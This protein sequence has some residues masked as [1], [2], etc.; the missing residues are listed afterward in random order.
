MI[1]TVTPPRVLRIYQVTHATGLSRASAYRLM[2]LGLF[3]K[4]IKIGITAV[5]WLAEDI[6]NFLM[7]R[8]LAAMTID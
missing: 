3:P 1:S 8:K 7:E 6:D 4:S 2:A 5:G